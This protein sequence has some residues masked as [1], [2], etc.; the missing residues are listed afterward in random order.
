MQRILCNTLQLSQWNQHFH[1]S[2]E[3]QKVDLSEPGVNEITPDAGT[4]CAKPRLVW[5]TSRRIR[6]IH[7]ACSHVERSPISVSLLSNSLFQLEI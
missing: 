5:F 1:T 2:Y 4:M 3:P 7:V 6:A